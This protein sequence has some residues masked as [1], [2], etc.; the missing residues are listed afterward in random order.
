MMLRDMV[1]A[2]SVARV[3]GAARSRPGEVALPDGV[4]LAVPGCERSLNSE[5]QLRERLRAKRQAKHQ[6]RMRAEQLEREKQQA[7]AAAEKQQQQKQQQ[8]QQSRSSR[9]GEQQTSVPC[10]R[11]TA[12]RA[13]A[14]AWASKRAGGSTAAD[15]LHGNLA[16]S[17]MKK[18]K[19]SFFR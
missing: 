12:T 15:D 9:K 6:Q 3:L 10:T 4:P 8:K 14:P 7:A 16:E 2:C 19:L 17:R 5:R 13:E 11:R 1:I 18:N